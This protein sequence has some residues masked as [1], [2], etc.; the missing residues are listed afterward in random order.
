MEKSKIWEIAKNSL[1]VLI[2]AAALY[3]VSTK[4]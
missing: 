1:N 4:I 2:K 3:W